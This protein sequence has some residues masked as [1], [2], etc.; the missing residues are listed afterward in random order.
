MA[1]IEDPI[2]FNEIPVGKLFISKYNNELIYKKISKETYSAIRSIGNGYTGLKTN[3]KDF[4]WNGF[5][6]FRPD[7]DGNQERCLY[8]LERYI[9]KI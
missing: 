7:P 4:T 3:R 9:I 1:K 2:A 6:S 5:N 8:L